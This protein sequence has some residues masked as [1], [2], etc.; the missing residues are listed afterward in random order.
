MGLCACYCPVPTMRLLCHVWFNLRTCYALSG[1]DDGTLRLFQVQD[2]PIDKRVAREVQRLSPHAYP[3]S[4]CCTA[5]AH[6]GRSLWTETAYDG[7]EKSG[8]RRVSV[9]EQHDGHRSTPLLAYAR[10]TT[11]PVLT[12]RMVLWHAW[13]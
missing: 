12:E 11:C 1:T 3:T 7:Q 13:Y 10:A 9:S 5:C 4:S 6:P 8:D 2:A